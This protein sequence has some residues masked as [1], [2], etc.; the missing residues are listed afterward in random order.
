MADL[1]FHFLIHPLIK[2]NI[3]KIIIFDLC[4]VFYSG[5]GFKDSGINISSFNPKSQIKN[6]E[7]SIGWDSSLKDSRKIPQNDV[8]LSSS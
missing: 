8:I 7:S 6:L 5:L 1:L 3:A 4:K 2:Y